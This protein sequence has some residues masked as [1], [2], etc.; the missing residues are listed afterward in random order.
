MGE[1]FKVMGTAKEPDRIDSMAKM[2]KAIINAR[3]GIHVDDLDAKEV[4]KVTDLMQ[5]SKK[6]A[7]FVL[8]FDGQWISYFTRVGSIK[9][10]GASWDLSAEKDFEKRNKILDGMFAY[11]IV[12]QAQIAAFNKAHPDV[13]G[14]AEEKKKLDA[15]KKTLDDAQKAYDEEKRKYTAMGGK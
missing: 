14:I 1:T 8:S 3:I 9:L 7:E 13:A 10:P 5:K 11:G 2:T 15:A 4:A 12:S 6:P